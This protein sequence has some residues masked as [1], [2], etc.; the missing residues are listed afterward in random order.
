MSK[1]SKQL[2]PAASGFII[3]K[4]ENNHI[5]FLGL[6]ALKKFQIK[7]KGI[8][9]VPKGRLDRGE[10]PLQAA[11]RE[12]WEEVG[13]KPKKVIAG[14]FKRERLCLWLAEENIE[15]TITPNP[16]TGYIEHNGYKWISPDEMINNCLD[17]LKPF[18]VWAHEEICKLH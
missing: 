17:Y 1:V 7:N 10:T 5:L 11:Y 9:D 15:P 12:C 3:Y 2:Q 6:V 4:K 13:I 8:Y 14:P 18:V 16:D